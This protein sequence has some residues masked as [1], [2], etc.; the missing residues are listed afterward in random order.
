[1]T[2]SWTHSVFFEFMCEPVFALLA[3][4]NY[5]YIDA[6]FSTF[7]T[8]R[9][10]DSYRTYAENLALRWPGYALQQSGHIMN[11]S[12]RIVCMDQLQNL[13][14]SKDLDRYEREKDIFFGPQARYTTGNASEQATVVY[15]TYPRSG[16]SLMRKYF[17]NVTGTATGSDMVIR[18]TSNVALQFCGFKAEGVTDS[19]TWINKTHFP[20]VLPFQWNWDA[21]IAVV[22]TRY[23]LDADPSFFYLVCTQC[24]SGAF[25][26]KLT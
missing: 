17:E 2:Q 5:I 10:D 14:R 7:S 3:R 26:N 25:K 13:L 4:H 18:H 9:I 6:N 19:R 8:R 16:N 24:H 15:A 21:D 1:M 12:D 20:Y 11:V 23:Q 22:C